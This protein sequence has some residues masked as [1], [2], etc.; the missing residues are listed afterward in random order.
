MEVSPQWIV[1][2]RLL[3]PQGRKGEL[4]AELSTDFPERFSESPD[5]WLA[6]E[7]FAGSE[8]A[9]PDAAATAARVADFWLP[10]GRNAG[11]IVLHFDGVDSIEAAEKIAGK[12]V[13]VPID[14]RVPLDEDAA[15]IDDLVGCA[16]Y[17]GETL[18]GTIE[19][20]EFP[21]TPDGLRRLEE[22]APLLA[23]ASV[24]GDEVLVPFAKA[25]LVSVDLPGKTIRM[26]LPEG[27]AEINR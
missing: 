27:L 4:L 18:L 20:V 15:Y 5:V 21:A 24:A 10:V 9:G 22:A 3:R 19:S 6:P 11:R 26:Q 14:R 17:D 25:F 23:I 1:L 13:V 16:V 12:E 8:F 7:G 2:A